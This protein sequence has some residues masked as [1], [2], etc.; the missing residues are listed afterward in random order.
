MRLVEAYIR[1]AIKSVSKHFT[2]QMQSGLL[3]GMRI[4]AVAGPKFARDEYEP[5][6]TRAFMENLREG[7][8]VYDIGAHWGY[9]SL[10]ASRRIGKSGQVIAFEPHPHNI[11]IIEKNLSL[12]RIDNVRLMKVAVADTEGEAAFD[13]GADTGL[14]KLS[15][16]GKYR[17]RVVSLD[18]LVQTG[19]I[20]PP[21]LVK[22]DIEGAEGRA[23]R[24]MRQVLEQYRPVVLLETHG[25]ESVTECRTLLTEIG[26]VEIPLQGEKRLMYRPPL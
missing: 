1:R 22:I 2:V 23:L 17:V 14:G 7:I 10:V 12:N 24:G 15:S 5:A 11:Q 19:E 4:V 3:D 21:N 26:Y 20:P 8:V 6:L 16:S 25:E 18:A 13:L 9:F